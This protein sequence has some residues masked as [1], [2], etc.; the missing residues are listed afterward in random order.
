VTY[1]ATKLDYS[2]A[3][4]SALQL[5]AVQ[6][7]CHALSCADTECSYLE[8]LH[9]GCFL[10][11]LVEGLVASQFRCYVFLKHAPE[12]QSDLTDGLP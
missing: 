9:A 11:H 10:L 6:L 7:S 1:T 2:Y 4:F 3:L 5:V 12:I 8:G